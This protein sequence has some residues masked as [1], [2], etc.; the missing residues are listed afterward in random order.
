MSTDRVPKPQIVALVWALV[1]GASCAAVIPLE[2]NL[3]EEGLILHVAQ[4]MLR[5]EHL[6]RDIASFTGPL[7]FDALTLLFRIFGEEIVVARGAIVVL[8]GASCAAV[9]DLARRAQAGALAHA[10]AA[11]VASAPIL[12][13]P[14]FS[15]YFYTTIATLL[16][17]IAGYAALRGTRSAGWALAAGLLIAAVALS[18]QTVGALLAAGL[19]TAM[20]AG[21][22]R[23]TRWHRVGAAAAGGALAA[24]LTLGSAA[25]RGDLG[26]LVH[27]LVV[28]PLS[29]TDSFDAPYMNFWPPGRFS[30]EIEPSKFMYVPFLYTLSRSVFAVVA[31]PMVLFTQ[32]LYAMPFLAIAATAVARL[33]QPLPPACW[34]HFATLIA[35][36]GN[37][38]PRTDWGHLVFVLPS[39]TLHLLLLFPVKTQGHANTGARVIVAG[40]LTALLAASDAF[41]ARDLHARSSDARFG[42]HVLLR[43]VSGMQSGDGVPRVIE[44][45]RRNTE[46]GEAIFVARAEPLIYFATETSNPTRY[47]GV[48]P[49]MREVQERNILA[50]LRDVRFVVMSEI[51]QPLYTYYRDELP[52]VQTYFE[53]HFTLPMAFRGRKNLSWITVLE[54]GPDRGPTATDL[55]E[56]ADRAKT[57]IRDA[58][59]RIRAAPES[60]PVL[61]SRHNRRPLP[62]LLGARGGGI[63]FELDLPEKAR[64]QGDVGFRRML[65]LSARYTHHDGG[66]MAVAIRTR[67]DGAFVRVGAVRVPFDRG[68]AY[69][70]LPVDL[71]LSRYAGQHVSLRLEMIAARK[72]ADGHM[73]WWGSPRITVTPPPTRKESSRPKGAN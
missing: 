9:Y 4:R 35:L 2:P 72:V 41:A 69:G 25:L 68:A 50:G 33:R 20:A 11:C 18:K 61:P 63:D 71:D 42:P 55:F 6:F 10:A 56:V 31:A 44:F 30:P 48:L 7:P 64:F 62:F 28:L 34:I 60:A 5:G 70:W 16:S 29:F 38:F 67:P 15:L 52:A 53:R 45:I 3:L 21:T 58:S 54:R 27:S 17:L 73:A 37:L 36:T 1:G 66:L 13:F 51:D 8:C 14:L 57:W 24:A 46:A 43:P 59:G 22:A 40:V 26:I 23:E 32:L 12:L 39:A 19:L 65:G 47:S 49:G